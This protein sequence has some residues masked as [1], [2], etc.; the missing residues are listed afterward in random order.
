MSFSFN[1][2]RLV[3]RQGGVLTFR[4]SVAIRVMRALMLLLA[5]MSLLVVAAAAF[6][7][8]REPDMSLEE[9]AASVWFILSRMLP[10]LAFFLIGFAWMAIPSRHVPVFDTGAGVLRQSGAET[11]LYLL[12]GLQLAAQ[13]ESHQLSVLLKDGTQRP[14]GT[15]RSMSLARATARRLATALFLPLEEPGG[16]MRLEPDVSA[17][18]FFLSPSASAAGGRGALFVDILSFSRMVRMDNGDIAVRLDRKGQLLL[19]LAGLGAA[20]LVAASLGEPDGFVILVYVLVVGGVLILY[21]RPRLAS[22][23]F[24]TVAGVYR[25]GDVE[26]PFA[27]I[28]AVQVLRGKALAEINLVLQDGN[29]MSVAAFPFG[30]FD[31]VLADA[32]ALAQVLRCDVQE[33][34]G[35]E[36]TWRENGGHNRD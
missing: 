26:I 33:A 6:L 3:Q 16:G 12:R 13:G 21:L 23:L 32:R 30:G 17:E 4:R 27:H 10:A 28:R 18:V 1:T 11:P 7:G 25:A 29:R 31:A 35:V 8:M 22:R 14:I 2:Y 24:D 34:A 36:G 20:W 19:A 5:M 15:C 9:V